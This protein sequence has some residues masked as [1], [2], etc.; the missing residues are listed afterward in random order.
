MSKRARSTLKILLVGS[1]GRMGR[2]VSRLR[3]VKVV[4]RANDPSDWDQLRPQGIDVVIDF[5]LPEGLNQALDW[6]LKYK[7]P[8]VSGT[9]GLSPSLRRKLRRVAKRVPVLYSANMSLG[10]AALNQMI[11]SLGPLA[12]WRFEISEIHHKRK[13]DKPSGTALLLAEQLQSATGRK[14]SQIVSYRKG[15]VVGIHTLLAA[16]PDESISL[17]HTAKK[18]RIFASG[19]VHAARWL[20]DKGKPGLYDL[21]DLYQTK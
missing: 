13:K 1:K 8:L 18:R 14:P 17:N 2:E 7:R 6:C 4:A 11:R 21:S 5:S 9:T 16:S 3:G 10:I 15:D 20:I 12:S 19:A